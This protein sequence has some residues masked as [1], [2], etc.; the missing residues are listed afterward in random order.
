MSYRLPGSLRQEFSTV[1]QQGNR[2][3]TLPLPPPTNMPVQAWFGG[4]F[5]PTFGAATADFPGGEFGWRSPIFDLQPQLRGLNPQ[6]ASGPNNPASRNAIPLWGRSG[7]LHVQITGL[8]ALAD[9]VVNTKL[10]GTES[11]H[12]SDPGQLQQV[13]PESDFTSTLNIQTNSVILSF[14]PYGQG[15]G[16]RY[17]RLNLRF[18]LTAALGQNPQYVIDASYY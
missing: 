6:G 15:T 2:P 3:A 18:G 4:R 12:I 8:T 9:S 16:V 14:R 5:V 11:A 10:L 13:L 1:G 17:W 7:V